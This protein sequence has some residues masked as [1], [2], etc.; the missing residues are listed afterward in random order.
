MT[1]IGRPASAQKY[2]ANGEH[3][4]LD[5]NGRGKIALIRIKIRVTLIESRA[6]PS[7]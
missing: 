6:S 5:L 1:Q 4:N 3:G 7:N 2:H